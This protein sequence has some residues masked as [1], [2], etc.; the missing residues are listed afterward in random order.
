MLENLKVMI[1]ENGG[2][3]EYNYNFFKDGFEEWAENLDADHTKEN[4][5][6]YLGECGYNV[7]E[8]KG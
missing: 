6:R 3:E 4:L 2:N 5:R 8:I 7:V 1:K